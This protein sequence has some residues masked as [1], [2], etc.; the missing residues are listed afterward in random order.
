[1][2]PISRRAIVCSPFAIAAAAGGAALAL[3]PARHAVAA[4]PAPGGNTAARYQVSYETV[5]AERTVTTTF[6]CNCALCQA[7]RAAGRAPLHLA[8][9]GVPAPA[10]G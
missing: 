9:A 4:E 8:A 10:G 3:Q 2:R 5:T 6:V 1:M 7:A